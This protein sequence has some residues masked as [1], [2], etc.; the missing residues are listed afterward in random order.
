[1]YRKAILLIIA[2][3]LTLA[4]AIVARAQPAPDAFMMRPVQRWIDAYNSGTALPEDIFTGDVVITDEFPPY[5]WTG[6]AGERAW[7]SAIDAFIKPGNQHVS[8]GAAQ[9]FQSSL[10]GT[11]VMFVLP[12]TLTFT[13]SRTGARV[14]QQALWLFVLAKD[15]DEWKIA[16]DTWT[17]KT[18]AS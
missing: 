12:A 3:A 2:L 11:R 15:G 18:P 7:A 8:V 16:A 9:S 6:E 17:T 4:P 14:T 13:S 5:V 1:M 10:R